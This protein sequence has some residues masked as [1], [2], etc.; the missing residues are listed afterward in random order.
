MPSPFWD[1]FGFRFFAN[2][3]PKEPAPPKKKKIEPIHPAVITRGPRSRL[4]TE[5]YGGLFVDHLPAP[6][7]YSPSYTHRLIENP[8]MLPL[9]VL[10]CEPVHQDFEEIAHA[11]YKHHIKQVVAYM[12]HWTDGEDLSLE[13]LK[14]GRL[15]FSYDPSHW[16]GH[17]PRGQALFRIS[18]RFF[19]PVL[20][21]NQ[22]QP[23]E[24]TWSQLEARL[25]ALQIPR[26]AVFHSC[27]KSHL[28][29]PLGFVYNAQAS[30]F[31]VEYVGTAGFSL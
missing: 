29:P 26:D 6:I 3:P 2:D 18:C 31:H 16:A 14:K 17:T 15:Y 21:L 30:V 27:H 4:R 1:L 10:T 20:L 22:A 8:R 5:Q 7:R 19:S 28:E 23:Y 11:L 25:D 13:D 12:Y 9:E 24:W